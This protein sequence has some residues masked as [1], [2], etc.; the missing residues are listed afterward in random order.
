MTN[1]DCYVTACYL[2]LNYKSVASRPCTKHGCRLQNFLFSR[3]TWSAYVLRWLSRL[4]LGSLTISDVAV[5]SYTVAG[6]GP[7]ARA[8]Y[9]LGKGTSNGKAMEYSCEVPQGR[10]RLVLARVAVSRVAPAIEHR[11]TH[12]SHPEIFTWDLLI[13]RENQK[14]SVAPSRV[15]VVYG[16]PHVLPLWHVRR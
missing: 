5:G 9:H 2:A 4:P 1:V 7:E 3:V 6:S 15:L 16:Y 11:D 8:V 12:C 10:R 13:K 14:E